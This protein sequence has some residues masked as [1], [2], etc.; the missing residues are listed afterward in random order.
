LRFL[1]DQNRSIR[2]AEKLNRSGHDAVHAGD[3]H[4]STAS[5]QEVLEA[6]RQSSRI[7]ISADTDFGALLANDSRK[8]PSVI[9]FRSRIHRTAEMQMIVLQD[10]LPTFREALEGGAIL[11][12]TDN[13]VRIRLLPLVVPDT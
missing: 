4:L 8:S 2:L 6:A 3:L 5:D 10:C 12:I 11:V 9:L 1:L 7:L 13:H